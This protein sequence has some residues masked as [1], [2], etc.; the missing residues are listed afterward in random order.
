MAET[1][2]AP[3]PG[4]SASGPGLSRRNFVLTMAATGAGLA[5]V[6][7]TWAQAAP[8]KDPLNTAIIGVG[9]QGKILLNQIL[10]LVPDLRVACIC[11]LSPYGQRL[12]RGLT[13]ALGRKE[14]VPVYDD[15]R[16]MLDK[17]K[18]LAAA[19]IATPDFTHA[20]ITIACLEK[21][22]HVY[23]EK[24]M[25]NGIDQAR[26]MVRAARK[27]GR[28]LQIGHQRRSNPYYRHAHRLC[29]KDQVMGPFRAVYGQWHQQRP[30]VGIPPMLIRDYPIAPEKL[31]EAGFASMDQW[32]NW[33]WF[34]NLAG[35]PMADL[36]SHQIDVFNWFLQF[37]PAAVQAHS[38]K[39][40]ALALAQAGDVGFVPE[41]DD[42]AMAVYEWKTAG[43]VVRGMYQVNMTTSH[44]GFYEVIMG[45]KGS[46]A[47]SEI[48]ALQ[49]MFKEAGAPALAW[50]DEAVKVE[51]ST[52]GQVMKFD[53]LASRK[54]VGRMDAEALKMAEDMK[55]DIYQLHLENFV[56][57][58]KGVE[59]LTCPGEVGLETCVAVL[60]A[61]E[62]ADTGKR[63]EF[64][65]DDFKV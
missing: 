14:E 56:A 17:E 40:R 53:P 39:E 48:L 26:Q 42:H 34:R 37:P 65:P 29:H 18:D 55:K 59:P 52:G 30:I 2:N 57:A 23:C 33:R 49:G 31:K 1:D 27:A 36:G 50:E 44:G 64:K 38:G 15:Y 25:S 4:D 8:P 13:K 28:K 10:T 22:L 11:D 63:I 9:R 41:M 6:R 16:Q 60:K 32:F 54:A 51:S 62:S 20:P 7:P 46:M 3:V 12:G 24:E 58:I 45:E 61:Q 35:G 43:G 5:I 21:G 47:L 19:V